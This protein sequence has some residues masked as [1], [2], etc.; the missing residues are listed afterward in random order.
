MGVLRSSSSCFIASRRSSSGLLGSCD[1]RVAELGALRASNDGAEESGEADRGEMVLIAGGEDL[2]DSGG[3]GIVDFSSSIAVGMMAA[4]LE[5]SRC[6]MNDSNYDLDGR[7]LQAGQRMGRD[8]KQREGKRVWG[9]TG[10]NK[11]TE[12]RSKQAYLC[13]TMRTTGRGSARCAMSGGGVSRGSPAVD[14]A[15]TATIMVPRPS[16]GWFR[17]ALHVMHLMQRVTDLEA[18]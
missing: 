4:E 2:A 18:V 12:K 5:R 17:M 15:V 8:S 14:R 7:G 9:R 16:R 6:Q 3:D 13:R 1:G 10:L 11:G